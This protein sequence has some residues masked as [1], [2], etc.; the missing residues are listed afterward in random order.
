[1]SP[2]TRPVADF[3]LAARH[4]ADFDPPGLD[5]LA[6]HHLHHGAGGAVENGGQRH[7][8]AAILAG[9]DQGA[10]D[11]F[12]SRR[13]FD[14]TAMVTWP[15]WLLGSTVGATPRHPAIDL[16]GADDLILADWLTLSLKAP[17]SAPGRSGRIRCGP[18]C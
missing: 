5:P 8:H 11:E 2:S 15:S 18:G 6:P 3:D 14:V 7:R 17:G 4:Q 13:W 1:M 16:A 12:T 9:L 10:P